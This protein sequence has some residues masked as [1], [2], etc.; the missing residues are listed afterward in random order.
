MN[1]SMFAL[2]TKYQYQRIQHLNLMKDYRL[3]VNRGQADTVC[4]YTYI[5]RFCGA[6]EETLDAIV[7][8]WHQRA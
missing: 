8:L 4:L 6:T 7:L 1:D 3:L 2:R 5:I